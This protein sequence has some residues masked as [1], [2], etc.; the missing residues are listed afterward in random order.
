VRDR[1]ALLI[2]AVLLVSAAAG[3][4]EAL[5][6]PPF[7]VIFVHG[8]ATD[9]GAWMTVS[10]GLTGA[11]WVLGGSPEFVQVSQT[12]TSVSAGD[13]YTM[14]FSDHDAAPFRSQ[15]LS[16]DRQGFEVSAVVQAVLAVNPDAQKV[17]LVAHSM[18]GL[19]AR[20]YLQGLAR[21]NAAA[22]PVPY[23]GD[24]A[25]L[26]V[27]AT[28]HQGSPLGT[29]CLA[30][31]AVC[32]S[33]GVNPTSVAVVELVPGSPALTALNDLGAR[34]LPADVRYE[35][36]AGLGGVGPASD[37]DG[38]VTRAS[39]EFLAGVPGLGHRLQEL[40]IPLRADCGHVVTIGNAVV[41]REVH[42]CETGDPGALVAAVDAILQPRLTL[43][44]NTSTISVGDTLTLT[45]GTEPGFPDQENVGDL[46]V[47][48]LVPG[49][50]VYVL[51][52]GGFSLA[53]HGGVVVPGALQPF[54]SSTIVSSGTEMILSAPIV[55]TIPAG[56]YTFAAVLV[57]PGTTPADAGNWLSNL[58][59]VSSTFK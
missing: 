50:D 41:F 14:N 55:T 40:I 59:T 34:P 56:P 58:A 4:A 17:I 24:V 2:L 25:Q 1:L 8:I 5:S 15:T 52:A 21:L 10:Q 7:P 48:L 22:A 42:T 30:F 32:V 6:K 11:G 13:F 46:Y 29:S 27:I 47:A 36:I 49:G 39:Q 51:T 35:S 20:E 37:G 23:R 28:P 38:I 12:V 53:F 44:V 43:T 19:A 9:A 33:V 3:G 45:L 16:F 54:R 57:S 31:A 26:I 18:G